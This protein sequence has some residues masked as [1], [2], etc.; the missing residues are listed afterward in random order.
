VA[1]GV[2]LIFAAF[3][4][5]AVLAVV[6]SYLAAKKR[7]EA[8]LAF[9]TS[10][11][12]RFEA[13]QPLLVDRFS[14]PPFGLGFGR[15]AYNVLYGSHEGRDLVSFDYEYKTQTTNGKQ[16]TTHTHR[17]SV[18][19]L[20][21]GVPMVPLSVDPENFLDRFVGRLTGNDIDME[22]EDFNRAF[23]VSCPDRK[24][25]SDVLHPQMMEFLLQHRQLGW[26]F[27]QDSMLVIASGA[28]TPEQIDATIAV[29]D[30]ISD[31]VPEFVW[32]RLK[33]QG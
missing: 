9:A 13:D 20:S 32:L 14:G 24:F 6:F 26:R 22:S 5:V 10:R 27:E 23:T 8:M 15:R 7:R 2:V 29:M 4:A 3:L 28:R 18:L 31:R 12:W 17:F 33:G 1:A 16:T 19:G 30:G 21:M 11:G 25:A